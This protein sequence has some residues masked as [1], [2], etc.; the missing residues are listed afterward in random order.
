[1]AL[2]NERSSFNQQICDEAA[3]S[4]KDDPCLID[5]NYRSDGIPLRGKSVAEYIMVEIC[6]S[7]QRHYDAPPQ[8]DM[9]EPLARM[10]RI[11]LES[12]RVNVEQLNAAKFILPRHYL[13]PHKFTTEM[14]TAALKHACSREV[15][16]REMLHAAERS[17]H[18]TNRSMQS[19]QRVFELLRLLQSLG[20]DINTVDSRTGQT[21]MH[22]LVQQNSFTVLSRYICAELPGVDWLAVD[23]DGRNFVQLARSL[24]SPHRRVTKSLCDMW[25]ARWRSVVVPELQDHL[26][27]MSQT[28]YVLAELVLSYLVQDPDA[29][30]TM[31]IEEEE[32]SDHDGYDAY[33]YSTERDNEQQAEEEEEEQQD[34]EQEEVVMP[35]DLDQQL[36]DALAAQV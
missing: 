29:P 30:H 4:L 27:V 31:T 17:E 5:L 26:P 1:V 25:E 9:L 16:S 24:H 32:E 21:V 22:H 36:I 12:G 28:E 2:L 20:A 8:R 13:Q 15:L 33:D 23:C 3:A 11:H 34:G 18:D 6:T 10:M 19:R 14:M 7:L 35:T